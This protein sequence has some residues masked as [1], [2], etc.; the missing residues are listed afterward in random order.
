MPKPN[1]KKPRKVV[2]DMASE[3]IVCPQCKGVYTH[4]AGCMRC[5]T[6]RDKGLPLEIMYMKTRNDNARL[7]DELKCL[8]GIVEKLLTGIKT[9]HHSHAMPISRR[10]GSTT[11]TCE[12][13]IK[14]AEAAKGKGDE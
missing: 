11:K 1:L 9:I 13:L 5:M 10:H 7:K 12:T 3:P 6:S 2:S 4:D 14:A 8:R